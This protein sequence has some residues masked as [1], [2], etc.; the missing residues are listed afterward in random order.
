MG[1]IMHNLLKLS[2]TVEMETHGPHVAILT[3]NPG[4][5]GGSD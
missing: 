5:S 2:E 3:Y 1:I 4:Y